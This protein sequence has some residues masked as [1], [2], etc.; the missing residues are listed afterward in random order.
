MSGLLNYYW[1]AAPGKTPDEIVNFLAQAFKKAVAEQGYIDAM[2]GMG[3]T[4]GWEGPAES[5]KTMD[6][7]DLLVK[8]IVKKYNLQP[9]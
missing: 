7:L 2:N 9:E 5:L 1:V 8:D 6:K 4:A 3:S